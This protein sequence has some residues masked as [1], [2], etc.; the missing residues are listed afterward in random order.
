MPEFDGAAPSTVSD[1]SP[2][3][4]RKRPLG[5]NSE[6]R[7][8]SPSRQGHP[9]DPH[10][11][12]GRR[13]IVASAA[14][15]STT[16][17]LPSA[18]HPPRSAQSQARASSLLHSHAGE[19]GPKNVSKH[20]I[21]HFSFLMVSPTFYYTSFHDAQLLCG[22]TVYYAMVRREFETRRPIDVIQTSPFCGHVEKCSYGTRGTIASGACRRS[23][24][25]QQ[26]C[27]YDT[28]WIE[29]YQS[30]SYCPIAIL[31]MNMMSP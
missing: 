24:L 27:C 16:L 29:W 18:S 7:P 22:S 21:S 20:I 3:R 30:S 26:P 15:A 2:T 23:L 25:E 1:A 12:K 6:A 11:S 13:T 28:I 19:C 4:I 9:P 14:S 8:F 10:I 17:S 31:L 5:D